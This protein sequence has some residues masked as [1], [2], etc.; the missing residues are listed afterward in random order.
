MKYYSDSFKD[1]LYRSDYTYYDKDK[2][3]WL[4]TDTLFRFEIMGE[5]YLEEISK[6]EALEILT[7]YYNLSDTEANK[8]LEE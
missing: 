1:C 8:T 7:K 5:G 3:T 4:E 2:K 6:N